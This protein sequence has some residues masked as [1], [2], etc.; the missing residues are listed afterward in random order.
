VVLALFAIGTFFSLSACRGYD[1]TPAKREQRIIWRSVGS[2]TGRGNRQTESFT[3][4]SGALR[5]RWD[6]KASTTNPGDGLFRLTAHSAI[7]GRPLEQ[8][9][10]VHG[11]GSGTG[12][13]S[14]DPHVFYMLVE[15]SGLDWQ[16]SVEE[17]IAAEV[18]QGDSR[19]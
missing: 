11:A 4:D 6:A 9:V 17:G 7:S 1:A 18:I 14:Q 13:V 16:F 15:S 2:W 3:S 10:E 5:V 19:R 8:V 12:Y